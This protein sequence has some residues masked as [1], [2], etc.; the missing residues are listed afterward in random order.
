MIEVPRWMKTAIF[1]AA[2]AMLIRAIVDGLRLIQ[3][4]RIHGF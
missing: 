4:I 1:L 3:A 2:M